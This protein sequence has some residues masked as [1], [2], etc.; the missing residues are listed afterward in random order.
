MRKVHLIYY[1]SILVGLAISSLVIPGQWLPIVALG[2]LLG[3]M[4]PSVASKVEPGAKQIATI[5]ARQQKS[6]RSFLMFVAAAL[7]LAGAFLISRALGDAEFANL[8]VWMPSHMA[9]FGGMLIGVALFL[10]ITV[11]RMAR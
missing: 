5:P 2:V 8:P 1:G 10:A 11:R 9:F 3:L 6:M 4:A 7:P